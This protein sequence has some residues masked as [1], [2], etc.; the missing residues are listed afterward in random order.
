MQRKE[1]VDGGKRQSNSELY[2]MVY[3][4]GILDG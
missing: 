2:D 3:L 1:W 4:Y